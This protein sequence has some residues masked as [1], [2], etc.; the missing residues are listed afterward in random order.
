MLPCVVTTKTQIR[1]TC[2]TGSS[3]CPI[4]VQAKGQCLNDTSWT[5]P[6]H[7]A[8]SLFVYKRHATV[9][10]DRSNF[11]ILSVTD[12]TQPEREIIQLEDYLLA[13]SA[14]VPGFS[15]INDTTSSTNATQG[16]NSAL[17]VYAVTALPVNDNAVAKKMSLAAIRKA[18]SVP[19]NYFHANYFSTQSLWELDEPRVGLSED[20]YTTLSLAVRSHQVIAGKVSRYLFGLFSFILL[21]LATSMI[22][23]TTTISERRPQRCGYPTLDFAA[24]CTAKTEPWD[25]SL[26]A[27]DVEMK[28]RRLSGLHRSLTQLG[29]KPGPFKVASKIKH[30]RI[31][32]S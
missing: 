6:L 22:I 7:L 8:S 17:A 31:A 16:D 1:L 9:N 28:R 3:Y 15:P 20:M 23:V 30:E 21:A 19:F 13:I 27:H 32:L 4:A 10:Y 12:L 18:M 14:V 11:S 26:S 2:G 25:M 5:S 24:V 29:E